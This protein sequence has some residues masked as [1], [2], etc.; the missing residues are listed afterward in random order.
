MSVSS[1]QIDEILPSS[2][3]FLKGQI[4]RMNRNEIVELPVGGKDAASL[5]MQE[6]ADRKNDNQSNVFEPAIIND[7]YVKVLK[8]R[9]SEQVFIE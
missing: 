8:G 9:N 4:R 3:D 2:A 1:M 7:E 5:T 6:K